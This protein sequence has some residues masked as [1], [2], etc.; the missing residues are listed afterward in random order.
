MAG[1]ETQP[2]VLGASYEAVL[3]EIL[4]GGVTAICGDLH[5]WRNRKKPVD[6]AN[7]QKFDKIKNNRD[8]SLY[9]SVRWY[10]RAL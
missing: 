3:H 6:K 10:I 4:G 2:R 1:G 5:E 7:G 8:M 9:E